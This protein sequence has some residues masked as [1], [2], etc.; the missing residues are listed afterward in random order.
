[1]ALILSDHKDSWLPR[2]AMMKDG[3]EISIQLT[4]TILLERIWESTMFTGS[5]QTQ[6]FPN[7]HPFLRANYIVRPYL[8]AHTVHCTWL[9]FLYSLQLYQYQHRQ[10]IPTLRIISSDQ[11]HVDI[12][13]WQKNLFIVLAMYFILCHMVICKCT[14][15]ICEG[16]QLLYWIAL[17]CCAV[18][19]NGQEDEDWGVMD[20]R[21]LNCLC[22]PDT[23]YLLP[24]T[25][26]PNIF[27]HIFITR[28][29]VDKQLN[30]HD[31][32]IHKYSKTSES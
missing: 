11:D 5:C 18:H 25:Q 4:R 17:D 32:A 1:M 27:S 16:K 21:K 19:T 7:A 14:M 2:G 26:I 23:K 3:T 31:Q 30:F 12:L 29:H 20:E 15:Y 10:D 22:R 24:G 28:F 13:K 9:P 8:C 6:S